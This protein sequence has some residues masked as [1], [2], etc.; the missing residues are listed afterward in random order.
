M[1]K[2]L[3]TSRHLRVLVLHLLQKREK[4]RID[5]GRTRQNAIFLWFAASNLS[6]FFLSLETTSPLMPMLLDDASLTFLNTYFVIDYQ[7]RHLL[8]FAFSVSISKLDKKNSTI[9]EG[10]RQ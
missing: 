1:R 5:R 6:T 8:P 9:D 7:M 10:H 2:H 4:H 3:A